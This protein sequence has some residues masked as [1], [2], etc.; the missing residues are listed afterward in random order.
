MRGELERLSRD[1][2]RRWDG[3]DLAV[4]ARLALAGD[5]FDEAAELAAA[6]HKLDPEQP[7]IEELLAEIERRRPAGRPSPRRHAVKLFE[8]GQVLPEQQGLV[9]GNLPG[10]DAAALHAHTSRLDEIEQGLA[11]G[12]GE[13]QHG[14]QWV[15]EQ[16]EA[17]IEMV[18][19]A[20]AE[21][22]AG[23]VSAMKLDDEPA[24]GLRQER[25]R[26]RDER[27]LRKPAG[28]RGPGLP[29]DGPPGRERVAP[30][31]TRRTLLSGGAGILLILLLIWPLWGGRLGGLAPQPTQTPTTMP[32]PQGAISTAAP[33]RAPTRT[34]TPSPTPTPTTPRT[35][36]PMVRVP[37]GSF[38]MGS[39]A[40]E[41]CRA[42]NEAPRHRVRISPFLLGRSE[43]TRGQ[44]AAFIRRTGYRTTAETVASAITY[45]GGRWEDRKGRSW[46][47]P[48]FRQTDAHPV[49]CV[50]WY[51]AVA[52]CNW[53]SE[54][55]GLQPCYSGKGDDIRCDFSA[56][57]YRLPTEAEWEYA[58]R[59]GTT[60]LYNMG[61]NLEGC[62]SEDTSRALD[63]AGWYWMNAGRK[64]HPVAAKS[65]NAWGLYDTH[66]NVWEWCWDRY[67]DEYYSSS[68]PANPKGPALG[69]FRVLRGGG[70]NRAAGFCRSAYRG[71]GRPG[72]RK[73]SIGFRIARS[74][75]QDGS[76]AWG[77]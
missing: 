73:S 39:L 51:D 63:R 46:R 4:R 65:A 57:G 66:G 22:P 64:T 60:G 15:L 9:A 34:R 47:N 14:V 24:R 26:P 42:R 75:S 43:V 50:S 2:V 31:V 10:K 71:R 21:K 53:L 18:D 76:R 72:V 13:R 30:T 54:E 29:E 45:E 67:G 70:W 16:A 68:P 62:D 32:T 36:I 52:F 58:C 1:P 55:E 74:V 61:D 5:W 17:G 35:L 8:R 20:R 77:Y 40:D 44:F 11:R 56:S 49:V 69:S 38:A 27:G 3:R 28:K 59:A 6:A 12:H 19:P 37:A 23:L 25:A 7:G 33:T 48:G 41:P